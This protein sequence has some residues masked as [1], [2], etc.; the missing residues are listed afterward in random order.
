M[1][2][3]AGRED[4][5]WGSRKT[6]C[7]A[8]RFQ[9]FHQTPRA[10]RD[11]QPG[12][13]GERIKSPQAA[14]RSRAAVEA[15]TIG[16]KRFSQPTWRR[17]ISPA[18]SSWPWADIPIT[19]FSGKRTRC[20]RPRR[21]RRRQPKILSSFSFRSCSGRG[22]GRGKVAP[23]FPH[24]GRSLA[25]GFAATSLFPWVLVDNIGRSS[26]PV[27]LKKECRTRYA[28]KLFH[29]PSRRPRDPWSTNW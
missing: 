22:D 6:P 27:S 20:G 17:T 14:D 5:R 2:R 8:L 7:D 16:T 25:L 15:K 26:R 11:G 24:G 1:G 13:G 10:K 3:G 9:A 23:C 4:S 19:E 21:R 12:D 18:L 28:G 29:G